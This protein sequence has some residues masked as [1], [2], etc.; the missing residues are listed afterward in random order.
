[1]RQQHRNRIPQLAHGLC[2]A[3]VEPEPIRKGLDS[4]TFAHSEV[5]NGAVIPDQHVFTAGNTMI[6]RL[7]GLRRQVQGTARVPG[8]HPRTV[9]ELMTRDLCGRARP[10]IWQVMNGI[11]DSAPWQRGQRRFHL[12]KLLDTAGQLGRYFRYR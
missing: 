6:P 12:P 4:R 5:T 10:R 1:M 2:P 7:E 9:L 8:I 3:A 11:P